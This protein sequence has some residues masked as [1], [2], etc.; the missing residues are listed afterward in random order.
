MSNLSII[1]LF[2]QHKPLKMYVKN[3]EI[4]ESLPE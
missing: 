4:F 3:S 1:N 2:H